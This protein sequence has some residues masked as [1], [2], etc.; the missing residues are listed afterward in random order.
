[1]ENTFVARQPILDH[2]QRLI[3][4]ELLFRES[5]HAN[6][7][8]VNNTNSGD[9]I[10][11]TL[12]TA[13]VISNTFAN[14]DY[15]AITGKRPAF[16][17]V[18]PEFL[19]N[20]DITGIPPKKVIIQIQDDVIIDLEL[21]N[22]VKNIQRQGYQI[23]LDNYRHSSNKHP[24]L[25]FV[26]YVKLDVTQTEPRDAMALIRTLKSF[27]VKL[28]A[29]RVEDLTTFTQCQDAEFDYFQGYF[30]CKPETM[31]NQTIAANQLAL[32]ELIAKLSNPSTRI[33]EIEAL[34]SQDAGL[35]IKLLALMNSTVYRIHRKITSLKRGH[36]TNW[37][38]QC[39][40]FRFY[41]CVI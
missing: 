9:G 16:I 26:S 7:S 35:S 39:P 11:G 17:H 5:E 10:D 34:V 37:P 15:A 24:L 36:C 30:F 33:E 3:G 2:Q 8:L 25:E 27:P 20:Y 22:A 28:I 12:A 1:M 38:G 29:K 19:V 6:E 32:V 14:F 40:A 31:T 21:V 13:N 18:N 4:Y 41:Y 23:A